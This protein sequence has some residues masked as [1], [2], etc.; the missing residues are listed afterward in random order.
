M[1]SSGMEFVTAKEVQFKP[2]T[3]LPDHVHTK[4]Y[5]CCILKGS[6]AGKYGS[7]FQEGRPT[8]TVFR[9]AGE[10]HS[11]RFHDVATHVLVIEFTLSFLRRIAEHRCV[12][13]VSSNFTNG[14]LT[15]LAKRLW[16][17]YLLSDSCSPLAVE[18][19][20]MEMLAQVTRQ[21]APA[22]QRIP[23]W[24]TQV[25]QQ[26]E[27]TCE[28]GLSVGI[29]AKTADVHPVYLVT[30]F[31]KAFRTTPGE[32][33]RQM[34]IRKAEQLMSKTPGIPLSEVALATG[35]FDQ[36]HFSRAF[37][38]VTGFTPSSFR[39]NCFKS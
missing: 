33:Q 29:L 8:E 6:Y 23:A 17:E 30:A 2:K 4:P 31:K 34:R 24:L 15:W 11:V 19:I 12:L 25:K 10:T 9:P 22:V 35:F 13:D 36:S 20:L 14:K 26:L 16:S 32:F 39:Q 38:Q 28:Q 27:E 37:R 1:E 21:H 3:I 7:K 5:F 18:G